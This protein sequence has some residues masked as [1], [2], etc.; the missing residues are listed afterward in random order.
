C[1]LHPQSLS[2]G[3][4]GRTMRLAAIALLVLPLAACTHFQN[5]YMRDTAGPSGPPK[6][7]EAVVVVFRPSTFGGNTQFPIFEFIKDEGILMGFT[8]SGHYFEYRCPP[9]RHLFLTW[10]EGGAYI[11]ADLAAKKTY[12]IRCFA[13]FG[14]IAPRPRFDPVRPGSEEWKNL[15]EE[16]KGLTRRELDPARAQY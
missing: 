16:L 11:E 14:F 6:D 9:G 3:S 8:E 7:N 15:D 5:E 1:N 2:S 4:G 13:Q 12:Y 10:G